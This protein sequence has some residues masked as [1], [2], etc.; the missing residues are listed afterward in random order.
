M[1]NKIYDCITFFDENLIVNARF[2]ILKGALKIIQ[3]SPFIGI[4]AASFTAIYKAETNLFKGHSH[5]LFTELAISYGL[6]VTVIFFSTISILL[7]LSYKSI[8]LKNYKKEKNFYDRAIWASIFFF[9]L[10]QMADIQYF[11]GR[12]SILAWILLISLKNIIYETK[13]QN[14]RKLLVKNV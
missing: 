8:F 7:I 3:I 5:N 4:G 11:D 6:P 10:S 13:D 2:E 12:I 1:Q 9:F 14:K